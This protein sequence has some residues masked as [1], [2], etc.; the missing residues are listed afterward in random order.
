MS[1]QQPPDD[2]A[3][4]PAGPSPGWHPDPGG[5]QALRWWDGTRWT[6]HTQPV[7]SHQPAYRDAASAAPEAYNT[8]GQESVGRHRQQGSPADGSVYMPGLY[9][10]SLPDTGARQLQDEYQPGGWPTQQLASEPTG[11]DYPPGPGVPRHASGSAPRRHRVRNTLI[12]S[13]AG[14]ILLLVGASI[15]AAGKTASPAAAPTVTVTAKAAPAPTVTVTKTAER[16]AA[17]SVSAH[18]SASAPAQSSGVLFTFSG[19]GI[20]NSAPFTVNSQVVTVRYSFD[21]SGAGGQGNFIADMVSGSPGSGNYD[22]QSIANQLGSGSSQT[23]TIY[24]QDP[25][26]SYHLE[27]HSEC[28]WS[29]TLTTG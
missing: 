6:Q 9:A 23:T 8:S 25:G 14:L 13:A 20:R 18:A 22:D 26:S 17:A 24:P 3:G 21:C 27:V 10:G 7:P 12:A 28:S 15:G 16:A 11:G 2:R 29:I 4:A 19:S 1:Y 5:P